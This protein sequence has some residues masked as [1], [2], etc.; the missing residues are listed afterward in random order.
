V[1]VENHGFYG[2]FNLRKPSNNSNMCIVSYRPKICVNGVIIYAGSRG[3]SSHI[4]KTALFGQVNKTIFTKTEEK[5]LF[6]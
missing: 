3:C 5:Y 1:V 4:H 6:I 2:E